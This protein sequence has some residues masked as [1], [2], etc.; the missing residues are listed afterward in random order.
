MKYVWPVT[1]SAGIRRCREPLTSW[2][3]APIQFDVNDM[4]QRADLAAQKFADV[5]PR[6][7]ALK[8]AVRRSASRI[9]SVGNAPLGN[10][11]LRQHV[12]DMP[13]KQQGCVF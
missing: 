10:I 6:H 13:G 9:D 12:I 4:R 3:S 7:F 5:P 2:P 1:L 8:V 11:D